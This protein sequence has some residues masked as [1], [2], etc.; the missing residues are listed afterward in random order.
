M[1]ST[2][3]SARALVFLILSQGCVGE[4]GD[5]SSPDESDAVPLA[6]TDKVAFGI[7]STYYDD[8]VAAV[9]GA[10]GFRGYARKPTATFPDGFVPATWPTPPG[11]TTVFTLYL[12]HDALLA[13]EFDQQLLSFYA[14]APA[15]SYV[16]LWQEVGNLNFS[17]WHV[18]P[19]NIASMNTYM[20]TL[21]N[22]NRG[23]RGTNQA[24]HVKFG[25]VII[26]VGAVDK[27]GGPEYTT[28]KDLMK[29]GPYDFYGLDI[30]DGPF[31]RN[32][33]GF[34]DQD[35]L[36]EKMGFFDT[37]AEQLS[38][39]QSPEI[40]IA[41]C[42]SPKLNNRPGFFTYLGEWMNAHHGTVMLTHFDD[43]GPDSG[44]WLD[45]EP[46]QQNGCN[47]IKAL[48]SLQAKYGN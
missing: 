35:T 37:M 3:Q 27:V 39:R 33:N 38:G 46:S 10:Q 28:L 13:H 1:T 45:C 32:E 9:P 4:L 41:E 25:P 16:T 19:S 31:L 7:N 12:E 8:F 43:G 42:N 36:D 47:T 34:V 6:S 40:V 48:E 30:Y 20:Q 26:G 2:D 11:V 29:G 21:I 18:D 22:N 5:S 23:G 17:E 44:K 24:N 14:T 15:T